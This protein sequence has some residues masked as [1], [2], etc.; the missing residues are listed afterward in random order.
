MIIQCLD[1]QLFVTINFNLHLLYFSTELYFLLHIAI[2]VSFA[3]LQCGI[4]VIICNTA[5]I[6]GIPQSLRGVSGL[7]A[8]GVLKKHHGT[9]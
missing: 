4:H 5:Q 1:N 6:H 9:P 3:V 2:A 7:Q 8:S